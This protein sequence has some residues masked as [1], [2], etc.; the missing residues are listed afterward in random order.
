MKKTADATILTPRP[1][2]EVLEHH[3][4]TKKTAINQG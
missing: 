2:W 3:N 4:P 1:A